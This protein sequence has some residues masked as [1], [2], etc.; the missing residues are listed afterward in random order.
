MHWP[1]GGIHCRV[2][3]TFPFIYNRFIERA[4]LNLATS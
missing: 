4:A 3:I 1:L 2:H